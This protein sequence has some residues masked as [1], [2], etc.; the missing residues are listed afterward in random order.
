MSCLHPN[1][2]NN[3]NVFSNYYEMVSLEDN[4]PAD[5]YITF[6]FDTVLLTK[7]TFV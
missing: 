5:N 1:I 4:H 2:L 7:K 3:S 6:Y